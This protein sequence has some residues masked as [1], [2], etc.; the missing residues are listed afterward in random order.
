MIDAFMFILK[1]HAIQVA[2]PIPIV[3]VAG[4]TVG[5]CNN[6]HQALL[7]PN[8]PRTWKGRSVNGEEGTVPAR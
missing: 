1:I 4:E 7:H 2:R 6:F 5:V 3:F 8:N